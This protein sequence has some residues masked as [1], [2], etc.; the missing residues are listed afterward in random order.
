T[1]LGE[2][3]LNAFEHAASIWAQRLRS[4]VPIRIR[5][6]FTPLAT[7]VL[8]SAGPA[9]VVRDFPNAPLAGTWYHVALANSLAGVDLNPTGDDINANFSTNFNFYLGL[10]GN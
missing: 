4:A 5:A 3:R 6:Q 9:T 2:Q 8:G 7:N 1:T 10:D